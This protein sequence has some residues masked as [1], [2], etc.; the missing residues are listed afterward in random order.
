MHLYGP[1]HYCFRTEL[2][3]ANIFAFVKHAEGVEAR[4]LDP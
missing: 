2:S 4:V 3:M 1:L